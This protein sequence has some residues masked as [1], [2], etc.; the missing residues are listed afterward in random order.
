[1]RHPTVHLDEYRDLAI[2]IVAL[3]IVFMIL[4]LILA[5]PVI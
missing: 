4:E 2:G 1:M 3:L 5:T